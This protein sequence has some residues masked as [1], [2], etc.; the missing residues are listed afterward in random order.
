MQISLVTHHEVL[1]LKIDNGKGVIAA[2]VARAF[3]CELSEYMGLSH[4]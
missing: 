1:C 4:C 3:S 2:V